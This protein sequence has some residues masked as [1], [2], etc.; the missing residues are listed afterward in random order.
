M[1]V[2]SDRAC[3]IA[4][5]RN[6]VSLSQITTSVRLTFSS[7]FDKNYSRD[8]TKDDID[9]GSASAKAGT[10]RFTQ[11]CWQLLHRFI[12][13]TGTTGSTNTSGSEDTLAPKLFFLLN[14]VPKV[15]CHLL[16]LQCLLG[17]HSCSLDML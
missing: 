12:C 13:V 2:A 4:R 3:R 9:D 5:C 17:L 10:C 16:G 6:G 7:G 1:V 15:T 11:Y 8:R 14:E